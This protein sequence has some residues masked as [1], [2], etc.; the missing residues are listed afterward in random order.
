ITFGNATG[1]EQLKGPFETTS[2]DL[3]IIS[4]SRSTSGNIWQENITLGP[5][6]VAAMTRYTTSTNLF[7]DSK[8][9]KSA[10]ANWMSAH[11]R[12][13]PKG[14]GW[15]ALA[16]QTVQARGTRICP[17]DDTGQRPTSC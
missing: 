14:S 12:T 16:G 11:P 10:N 8:K 17:R 4:I 5:G 15:S 13:P 3:F 7:G 2:W 9:K 1:N 6:A